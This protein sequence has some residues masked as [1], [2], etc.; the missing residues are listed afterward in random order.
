[1]SDPDL[2]ETER[3][4]LSGWRADQVDDLVALHGNPN[5]SRY[6]RVTGTPWTREQAEKAVAHWIE[7]F[8][9]HQFG[10]VRVGRRSESGLVGRAG[11]AN[12]PP[13]GEPDIGYAHDEAFHGAGHATDAAAGFRDWFFA[14]EKGEPFIAM[15]DTRRAPPLAVLEKIG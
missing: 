6:L 13:T 14:N 4:V 10:M 8:E 1:M 5:V 3:L 9:K 2:F 15:A 12:C 11:F 7:L